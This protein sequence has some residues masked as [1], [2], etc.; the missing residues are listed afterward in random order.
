MSAR[1]APAVSSQDL[2]RIVAGESAVASAKRNSGG[3]C[4]AGVRS[5]SAR[6]FAERSS[7]AVTTRVRNAFHPK[8]RV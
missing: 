7:F 2:P 3:F 8:R 4:N 1:D 6:M 5:T